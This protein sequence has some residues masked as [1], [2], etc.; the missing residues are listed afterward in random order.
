MS[1]ATKVKKCLALGHGA[2]CE[3]AGKA[4]EPIST[5]WANCWRAHHA[6]AVARVEQM[7]READEMGSML[8][9]YRSEISGL[10]E[11]I[12]DLSGS[13]DLGTAAIDALRRIMM[14]V[15]HLMT[16]APG[17]VIPPTLRDDLQDALITVSGVLARALQKDKS[18]E[19]VPQ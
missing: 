2:D 12:R 3:G 6:C 18:D 14:P 9:E 1:G 13:A 4:C 15:H 10:N 5:H 11:E 7:A 8:T 19:G 16:L 17:R